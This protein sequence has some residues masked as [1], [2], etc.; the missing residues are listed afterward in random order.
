MTDTRSGLRYEL[1]YWDGLQGR[2]E[3]IRLAL[4]EAGAEYV[5]VAREPASKH[6]GTAAMLA[7]IQD[8]HAMVIP[9]A[10]PFLKAGDLII[11]QTAN[12]LLYLGGRHRLAPND[13]QG[14]YWAHALQL[15]IA[16]MVAEVHD[17]HHPISNDL[18]YEDQKPAAKQRSEAF[19]DA[20]VPKFLGYFER[21]LEQNPAGDAWMVGGE[22]TYVDLS[23]FQLLE[24]LHYAFPHAMADSAVQCRRSPRC[25]SAC[26]HCLGSRGTSHRRAGFRSTSPASFGTIPNWIGTRLRAGRN[27]ALE[28]PRREQ[29]R[30]GGC[31]MPL[32]RRTLENPQCAIRGSLRNVLNR[33]GTCGSSESTTAA[34]RMRTGRRRR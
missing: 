8:R 26:V 13:E 2:G 30:Q 3:F 27:E 10:P 33:L 22:R 12:A 17:T 32:R 14:K 6:G 9:F 19:L 21:V 20:R 16:D 28:R 7:P 11:A 1:H 29:P 15:T 4:E 23:I 18:Y 34:T 31:A 5:D 25:V 24:G